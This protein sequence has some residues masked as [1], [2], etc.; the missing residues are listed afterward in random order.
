[1]TRSITIN[2]PPD[3]VVVVP[4]RTVGVI[5]ISPTVKPGPKGSQILKGAGAPTSGI[6]QNGDYYVQ[7]DA[8]GLPLF[9]PK[10]NGAW[11]S[12]AVYS[13]SNQRYTHNQPA[14]SDTW[15]IT[16]P[17]GGYPS[18]TIV[19]SA[20]TVV[21]GTVEYNSTSQVTVSFSVPFSGN[22]YLT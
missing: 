18:V 11:P 9:G 6:G 5:E 4:E 22:A 7:E 12:I 19:D 14:A 10:T 3:R 13:N 15:V 16:H 21:I 1:V 20:N 8:P 2:K 17:L